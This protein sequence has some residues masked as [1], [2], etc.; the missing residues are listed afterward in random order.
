VVRQVRWTEQQLRDLQD[1]I[2]ADLDWMAAIPARGQSVEVDIEHNAVLIRIS[3]AQPAATRMILEHYAVEPTMI[4]V[5]S[6]G[7]GVVLLPSG[8]VRGR[9]VD[10]S[11]KPVRGAAAT[12]FSEPRSIL[13]SDG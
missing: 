11:G 12:V 6:D 1:R 8:T 9:V 13:A 10:A 5:E 3:S 4:V 2:V 7:T